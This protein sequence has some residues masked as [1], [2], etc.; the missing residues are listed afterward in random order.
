VTTNLFSDTSKEYLEKMTATIKSHIRYPKISGFISDSPN[1]ETGI[2]FFLKKHNADCLAMYTYH[3]SILDKL[4]RLSI[5][6]SVAV[7][8]S[9]PLLVIHETDFKEEHVHPNLKAAVMN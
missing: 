5:T 8:T 3:K 7:H 6:K 1:V 9:I 4:F 2:N